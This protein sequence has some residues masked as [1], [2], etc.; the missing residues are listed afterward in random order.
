VSLHVC[1]LLCGVGC[2]DVEVEERKEIVW[3]GRGI[4][5]FEC[6]CGCGRV[7]LVGGFGP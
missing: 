5:V 2:K 7:G 3:Q 6:G 4:R 1:V